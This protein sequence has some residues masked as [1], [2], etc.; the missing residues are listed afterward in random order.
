VSIKTVSNVVHGYT[1]VTEEMRKRVREA[2]EELQYQ[3]NLPARY[4]RK[5]RVGI[6]ALAIPDFSNSYFSDIGSAVMKTAS[7][8][9]YKV[10]IDH[11][12]GDHVKEL[13]VLNGLRLHLIDGIIF[14]PVSLELE[15][16]QSQKPEVPL[17]LI[18]ERF[19]D[20]PYDH[21]AIDNIAAAH[22]ATQHLVQLGRRHIA[23]IGAYPTLSGET[24]R[25]RLQG[26]KQALAE[27]NLP[28]DLHMVI[29]TEF[30]HRIDGFQAVRQLLTLEQL[31]DAIFC[32]N[33]LIALGAIRALHEAGY[34][35]PEDVAIVGFDDIE[36][37]RY[38]TPS[39]TTIR[40]NKEKIGVS[41]VSLLTERIEGAHSSE[42]QYVEVPFHL[43]IRESTVGRSVGK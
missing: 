14:S 20:A 33:D 17:V 11:T 22:A 29:Q 42:P 37:G 16:L 3:P 2:L 36:D 26:Y 35:V 27:A 19:L 30:Y 28:F 18:G 12:D 15:D 1:H 34:R 40:P 4:L 39:L 6:L 5:S 31:P 24:G 23:A 41:A 21:I 32:F 25:L 8:R 9:S 7:N 13:L 38:A 43:I 10:L